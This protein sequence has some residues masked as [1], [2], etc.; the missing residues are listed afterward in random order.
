M[1]FRALLRGLVAAPR[2]ARLLARTA[3]PLAIAATLTVGV[4][5]ALAAPT[6]LVGSSATQTFAESN[7]AGV[8]RAFRY[9]AASSG[10]VDELNVFLDASSTAASVHVGLFS[11]SSDRPHTRLTTCTVLAPRSGWNACTAPAATVTVGATYWLAVLAPSDT[12]GRLVVRDRPRNGAVSYASSKASLTSMPALFPMGSKRNGFSPA[13]IYGATATAPV[14]ATAP[15]VPAGLSKTAASATSVSLAWTASTDAVGVSGY[16]VYRDG[17]LAGA[18]AA[19]TSVVSGLACGTGYDF[20]VEAYDAAGNTSARATLASGT[21]ACPDT[22]APTVP[23]GFASTGAT[24]TSIS[25][26]WNASTDNTAVAGYRVFRN[27]AA[28]ATTTNLTYTLTGL[29]CGTSYTVSLEAFD[30]AGNASNR[31]LATSATSTV[32]VPGARRPTPTASPTPS[33][34]ASPTATPV[35]GCAGAVGAERDGVD[36][37]HAD[38]DR[39][40]LGCVDGQRRRDGLSPVPRRCGGRDDDEPDLHGGRAYVWDVVHDRVGGL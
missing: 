33:P 12:G 34:T 15:S 11:S 25:L 21:G 8:A 18:G 1:S 13:S 10:S 29:V 31:A 27:G 38:V 6:P 5:P 4:S 36:D 2:A 30:A 3:G 22:Q 16:R 32:G 26:N 39:V 20:A 9:T 40:A 17:V 23:P 7:A 19:T 14:D 37:D 28:V 35:A 24:Q